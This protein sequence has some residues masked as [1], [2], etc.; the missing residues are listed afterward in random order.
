MHRTLDTRRFILALLLI[1]LAFFMLEQ[2]PLPAQLFA[3]T[4]FTVVDTGT[5]GKPD[6]ILIPGLNSS[7][8]VW[9]GEV[10]LLSP[11]YRLH[12]VQ[13]NGFAGQPTGPNANG[14]ILPGIVDELHHYIASSKMK[15]EV[16]GHSMG[17]LLAMILAIQHPEDVRKLVIVDSL[18]T[19]AKMFSPDAT[20]E[21]IAPQLAAMKQ[22]MANLPDDQY[23]AMQPLMA[24]RLCKSPEGQKLVADAAAHS[25]RTVAL[26]AMIEDLQTDLHADVAKISAP[27]LMLYPLEEPKQKAAETDALY[28]DA[29]K[30]LPNVTLKRI[31][32]SRHFIMYDQPAALDA[33]LEA[34]LK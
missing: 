8:S 22:Q 28:R 31:D 5:V 29:Y 16:V 24:A 21:S 1:A 17:G 32:D 34:F 33:A 12:L 19:A 14:P 23:T 11:N 25:D 27:T 2:R 4:R 3:P 13:V 10:K 18:P 20:P 15:P 9:D 7:R 30:P 6:V 26:N